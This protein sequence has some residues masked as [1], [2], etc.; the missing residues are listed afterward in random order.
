MAVSKAGKASEVT[1]CGNE[2]AAVLGGKSGMIRIRDELAACLGFATQVREEDPARGAVRKR[3]RLRS[4]TQPLAKLEGIPKSRGLIPYLR[5]RHDSDEGAKAQLGELV[6]PW[7][8]CQ[9]GLDRGLRSSASN[10]AARMAITMQSLMH[11][12]SAQAQSAQHVEARGSARL[13]V[14]S[15]VVVGEQTRLEYGRLFVVHVGANQRDEVGCG[16]RQ[17]SARERLAC[18]LLRVCA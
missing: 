11:D 3:P 10:R 12:A 17:R 2:L 4:K 16:R 7:P 8:A 5:I 15:A 18:E 6:R 14:V 1:V 13:D 9:A